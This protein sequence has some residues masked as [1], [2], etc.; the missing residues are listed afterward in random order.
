MDPQRDGHKRRVVLVKDFPMAQ[1]K[2][3]GIDE[4][5]RPVRQLLSDTIHSCV[6]EA[7]VYPED[8]RN[9]RFFPMA[10]EDLF[11][12]AGRSDSYTIIEIAMI[13]GRSVETRK[14]LVRLLFQRIDSL[15]GIEPIDLEI[16]ILEIPAENWGFRG[17]HGDE[18]TLNYSINV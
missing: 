14:N 4:Q 11:P 9:H 2:I 16:C 6:C 8:K 15:V 3:Y 18:I 1:V 13:T 5:L 10:K 17:Q 7:L 12:P